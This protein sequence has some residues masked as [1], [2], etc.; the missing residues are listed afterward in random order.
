[1]RILITCWPWNDLGNPSWI[2]TLV[3]IFIIRYF[4]PHHFSVVRRR[5]IPSYS[6]I[7]MSVLY[8]KMFGLDFVHSLIRSKVTRS[9]DRPI[10]FQH[11]A[12]PDLSFQYF[13]LKF[14]MWIPLCMLIYL[15]VFAYG[16][17]LIFSPAGVAQN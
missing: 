15:T 6:C 4:S 14:R 8:V 17:S 9:R 7:R 13:C 2:Y 3:Q 10:F 5:S 12:S 16:L 1:M 11:F